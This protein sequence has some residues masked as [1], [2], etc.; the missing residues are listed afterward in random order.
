MSLWRQLHH[1]MRVLTNRRA[2]DRDLDDET[3]HYLEEITASLQ[4]EGMSPDK[5]RRNARIELGSAIAVREQV[6]VRTP[7]SVAMVSDNMARELWGSSQSA[8]GQ[9]IRQSLNQEWRSVVGVVA[10]LR[11][12]GVDRE[13]PSIVFWPLNAQ[14]HVDFLIRSPRAGSASFVQELRHQL[15]AVH[16]DLPLAKVRTLDAVYQRSLGRSRFALFLLAV[17]GLMA[18]L[19]GVV[20]IYGVVAYSVTRRT[21]REGL[22]LSSIGAAL[23][24]VTAVAVMR[25]MRS[26]LFGVSPVDPLT[27]AAA[28]VSLTLAA[29]AASWLP[30]RRAA[31]VDP[32]EALRAE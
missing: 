16:G 31:N 30:A 4:A 12:D 28:L 3:R 26:L 18:L 10:D 7:T 2:A 20:G 1:G 25:L 24:L 6:R 17:A 14:R 9:R 19:L 32:I 5:A 27:Y 13:A 29:G 11:D 8:L 23:G 15:A 22:L 21:V